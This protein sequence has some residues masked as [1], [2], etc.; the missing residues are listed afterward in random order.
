[1]SLF[2]ADLDPAAVE[3]R[4]LEKL[5]RAAVDTN[6]LFIDNLKVP[7]SDLIGG[8]GR[9]FHCLL[10]GLNPERI[11]VAAEAI[12]IGTR[13]DHESRPLREGT[14]RLRSPDRT[15]PGHRASAGRFVSKLEAAELMMLKA[16]W[17]FDH[18]KPCGPEANTAKLRA[19]DAAIRSLRSRGA[20]PRRIRICARLRR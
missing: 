9:G 3:V 16:A 1:M 14:H 20:N 7:A 13:R 12:G 2:F 8:E 10:D 15:E 6:M 19:A 18:R 5:G 11:L 4:E 17:L